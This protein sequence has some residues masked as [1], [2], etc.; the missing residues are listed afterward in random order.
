MDKMDAHILYGEELMR[1]RVDALPPGGEV[2]IIGPIS[3]QA[4]GI[5]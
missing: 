2:E 4:P 5:I 1:Q 3:D